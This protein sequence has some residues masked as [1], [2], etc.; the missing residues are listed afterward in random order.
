MCAERLLR[1]KQNM[2]LDDRPDNQ[3][4]RVPRPKRY[5]V[6]AAATTGHKE[7]AFCTDLV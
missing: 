3:R 6:Q 1:E 4:L 2:I 5:T 7:I